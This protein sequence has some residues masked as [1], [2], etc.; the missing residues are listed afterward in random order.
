MEAKLRSVLKNPNLRLLLIKLPVFGLALLWF[1]KSGGL[2]SLFAFTSITLW[3]YHRVSPLGFRIL[4][5]LTAFIILL[6]SLPAYHSLEVYIVLTIIVFIY[7]LLG[8][9]A[10][11]FAKRQSIYYFINI[12]LSIAATALY[13]LDIIHL[14]IFILILFIL[15]RELYINMAPQISLPIIHLTAL[16]GTLLVIE[17]AW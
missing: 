13:F 15:F 10:L 16:T 17:I 12:S 2:L 11:F 8:V 4:G 3:L 14:L 1:R 5:S 7:F 6:I 9:K